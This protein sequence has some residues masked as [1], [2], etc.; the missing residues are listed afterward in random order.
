MPAISV[1]ESVAFVQIFMDVVRS[2]DTN[3]VRFRDLEE[4]MFGV[5]NVFAG[6]MLVIMPVIVTAAP[7]TT[8]SAPIHPYHGIDIAPV[9]SVT[10][11]HFMFDRHE[12][13]LSNGFWTE[14][15]R[16]DEAV[17][18]SLGLRQR[19]QILRLFPDLEYEHGRKAY[20]TARRALSADECK[21]LSGS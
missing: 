1:E 11:I 21:L 9:Q 7:Q 13:V 15:L 12:V 17:L 19:Q 6:F 14:S 20:R 4:V 5:V 10:Y 2:V 8:A 18:D 16:P 3:V